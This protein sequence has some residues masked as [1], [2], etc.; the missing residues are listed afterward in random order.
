[1]TSA[2]RFA[3][4]LLALCV[5]VVSEARSAN[6]GP[7]SAPLR[8]VSFNTAMG[9]GIKWFSQ[10]SVAQFFEEEPALSGAHVFSLQEVCLND[11]R[12]LAPYLRLMQRT[13]KVQYHYTDYASTNLAERCDKG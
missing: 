9:L 3:R 13:H 6:A 11:R 8:V 7:A 4:L 10:R 1:M 5:A 12:Q 2:S